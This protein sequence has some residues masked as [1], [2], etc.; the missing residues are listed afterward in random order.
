M[1]VRRKAVGDLAVD[2]RL[3]EPRRRCV[4]F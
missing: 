1:V 2:L 4:H 3:A